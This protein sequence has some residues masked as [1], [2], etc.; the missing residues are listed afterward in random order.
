[1]GSKSATGLKADWVELPA[2][3]FKTINFGE[4][5]V[6]QKF[7]SLP[8]P[9]DNHGH[10]GLRGFHCLFIKTEKRVAKTECGLTYGIPHGRSINLKTGSTCD[11]PH[12]MYVIPIE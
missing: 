5:K 8:H 3:C 1:M 4:L 12:G 7:I 6:G 11:V 10:G 9:G 2:E